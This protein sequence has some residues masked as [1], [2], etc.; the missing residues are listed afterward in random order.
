M[1]MFKISFPPDFNILNETCDECLNR[2]KIY[3]GALF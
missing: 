1:N 3:H 2:D